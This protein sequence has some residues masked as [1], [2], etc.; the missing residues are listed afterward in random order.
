MHEERESERGAPEQGGMPLTHH[1]QPSGFFEAA[2][3]EDVG[4]APVEG[5]LAELL[6]A[7]RWDAAWID[8]A[9]PSGALAWR[10][11]RR[12]AALAPSPSAIT[13]AE[14]PRAVKAEKRERG[15]PAPPGLSHSQLRSCTQLALLLHTRQ[16]TAPMSSGGA[17]C[18]RS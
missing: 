11:V 9:N 18:S 12:I 10:Y 5:K 1:I 13:V 14:P 8:C 4:Q 15:L 3:L 2:L 6:E 16:R 7:A 17:R